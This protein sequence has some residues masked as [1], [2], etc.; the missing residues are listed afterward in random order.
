MASYQSK[1][2]GIVT[3]LAALGILFRSGRI[4]IHKRHWLLGFISFLWFEY[5]IAYYIIKVNDMYK[6]VICLCAAKED[7]GHLPAST[8]TCYIHIIMQSIASCWGMAAF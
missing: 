6:K 3:G 1:L 7:D 5:S 8:K 4:N 2:G